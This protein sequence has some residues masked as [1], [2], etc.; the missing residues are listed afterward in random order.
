[1][2]RSWQRTAQTHDCEQG[3]S[4]TRFPAPNVCAHTGA[5]IA[6]G[7]QFYLWQADRYLQ[8]GMTYQLGISF[9]LAWSSVFL[10]LI[11]GL[12]GKGLGSGV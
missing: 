2:G 3:S 1:M 4:D 6:L 9:Y 5:S 12:A 10:F 11:T 7:V 8:E